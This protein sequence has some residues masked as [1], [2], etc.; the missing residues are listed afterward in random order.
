MDTVLDFFKTNIYAHFILTGF[1]IGILAR[2]LMPGKDPMGI[3]K[4]TFLGITGSF[5]SGYA[6][7][8]YNIQLP[9]PT[10]WDSYTAAIVGALLILS[11]F[12]LIRN[13]G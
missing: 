4:T 9:I 10:P 5:L 8:A 13:I 7:K 11:V 12:K 6:V 3:I 1:V 2:I